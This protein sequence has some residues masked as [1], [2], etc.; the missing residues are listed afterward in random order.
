MTDNVRP[1]IDWSRLPKDE[2]ALVWHVGR[3][4]MKL[5]V[6]CKTDEDR[7]KIIILI[8]GLELKNTEHTE[9]HKLFIESII[10]EMKKQEHGDWQDEW[11]DET[12]LA[13]PV[14]RIGLLL[15]HPIC[16][17]YMELIWIKIHLN[18]TQVLSIKPSIIH[19]Q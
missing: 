13:M 17:F 1:I 8:K 12:W 18:D 7:N 14:N 19:N 15:D 11:E 4:H 16:M 9:D 2:I 6:P 10:P 5:T 3:I